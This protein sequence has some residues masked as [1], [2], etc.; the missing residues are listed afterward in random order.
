[1]K[2]RN[3]RLWLIGVFAVLL[4]AVAVPLAVAQGTLHLTCQ[5]NC[6]VTFVTANMFAPA[7]FEAG[8]ISALF[9]LILILAAVIFVLVEGLLFFAVFAIIK[10]NQRRF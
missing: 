1:M 3:S 4:I 2:K 7:S 9:N 6:M 10:D 5:P 8:R